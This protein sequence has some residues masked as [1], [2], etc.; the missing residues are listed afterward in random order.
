MCR[1]VPVC[2]CV[3]VSGTK[4]QLKGKR[5]N[6]YAKCLKVESHR[7]RQH[8]DLKLLAPLE[9]HPINSDVLKIK[10]FFACHYGL[11]CY[12]YLQNT[13]IAY[14]ELYC[15][16]NNAVLAPAQSGAAKQRVYFLFCFFVFIVWVLFEDCIIT[17]NVSLSMPDQTRTVE[18]EI[19]LPITPAEQR[20]NVVSNNQTSAMQ[21]IFV[22]MEMAWER[23]LLR[24]ALAWIIACVR[25]KLEENNLNG[26]ICFIDL[27]CCSYYSLQ[28]P[29]LQSC[30]LARVCRDS[31]CTDRRSR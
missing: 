7:R 9:T 11:I 21:W 16:Y 5:A 3:C 22:N 10:C 29:R 24:N 18:Y 15:D 30:F 17:K 8:A 12:L 13:F 1:D 23:D 25:Q 27:N 6:K 2:V 14:Y 28:P 19:N 26:I 31:S 4:Q 20:Y